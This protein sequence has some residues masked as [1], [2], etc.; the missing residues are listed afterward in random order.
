MMMPSGLIT[1]H[2]KYRTSTSAGPHLMIE[3]ADDGAGIP[4]DKLASLFES[5]RGQP[6]AGLGLTMLFC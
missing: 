2:V 4:A 1:V 5:K 6:P 3:V